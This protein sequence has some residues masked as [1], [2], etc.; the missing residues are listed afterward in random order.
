MSH[1]NERSVNDGGHV[2]PL[3]MAV[4]GL[5]IE[6]M[7]LSVNDRD[8]VIMSNGGHMTLSVIN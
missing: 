6:V 2:T 5:I 1:N 4:W 3:L 7:W 8:H